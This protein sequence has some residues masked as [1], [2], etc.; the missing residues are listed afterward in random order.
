MSSSSQLWISCYFLVFSSAST[1]VAGFWPF[2]SDLFSP[3]SSATAVSRSVLLQMDLSNYMKLCKARVPD[4]Q[5][6]PIGFAGHLIFS[7]A[8]QKLARD[9]VRYQENQLDTITKQHVAEE[10]Y[11]E[12]FAKDQLIRH[13]L[14]MTTLE[15][16]ACSYVSKHISLILDRAH[17]LTVSNNTVTIPG[18]RP[19]VWKDY[20]A[21][22]LYYRASVFSSVCSSLTLFVVLLQKT[23]LGRAFIFLFKPGTLRSSTST[24]QSSSQSSTTSNRL[25]IGPMQRMIL[26]RSGLKTF[27]SH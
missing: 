10:H 6:H 20:K 17:N 16:N 11:Y 3:R 14:E 7:Q 12:S 13:F 18:I 19:P 2:L 24:S 27:K 4:W 1:C 8:V 22:L 21:F 26:A 25:A 23:H 15:L 9:L 5:K